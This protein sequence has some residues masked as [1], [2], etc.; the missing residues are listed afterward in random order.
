MSEQKINV[1]DMINRYAESV[2]LSREQ[3]YKPEKGSWNW[4]MGSAQ[5]KIYIETIVFNNGTIREYLRIFSPLM[6]VPQS[7]QTRFYRHL[8]E[9][10]D[11]NLGVKLTII[12]NS[13][14]VYATYE[15]DIR[16]MDYDEVATCIYDLELWADKLDDELKNKFGN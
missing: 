5:I 16:G 7:D 3:V 12:P 1:I 6:E 11:G 2:G 9:L 8:L 15:R 10:N 13:T 4:K 14:W